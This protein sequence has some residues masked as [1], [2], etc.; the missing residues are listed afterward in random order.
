V[1]ISRI[2]SGIRNLLSNKLTIDAEGMAMPQL[3]RPHLWEMIGYR[4]IYWI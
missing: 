1:M 3:I 2:G 4:L